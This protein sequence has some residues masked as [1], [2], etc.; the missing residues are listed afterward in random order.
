MQQKQRNSNDDNQK[1]SR[2][3]DNEVATTWE[4]VLCASV[5]A[6]EQ[7]CDHRSMGFMKAA[8]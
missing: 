8:A 3:H 7:I 4:T 5:P 1:G 6:N 2:W